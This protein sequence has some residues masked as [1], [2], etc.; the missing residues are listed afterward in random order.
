MPAAGV[1]AP[2]GCPAAVVE[3]QPRLKSPIRRIAAPTQ[4]GIPHHNPRPTNNK[5][6]SGANAVPR[7]SKAFKPKTA[8][9]TLCGKNAAA[10]V[11][12]AGTVNPNPTPMEAVAA[13]S[14]T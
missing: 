8:V 12:R 11:L 3:G 9:S 2:L 5:T 4:I 13:S 1:R 10:N 7:P 14:S 6:N